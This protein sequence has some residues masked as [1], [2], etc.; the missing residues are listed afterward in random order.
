MEGLFCYCDVLLAFYRIEFAGNLQ[1]LAFIGY[2]EGTYPSKKFGVNGIGT[3]FPT[4][5]VEVPT[6]FPS[7]MEGSH[8]FAQFTSAALPVAEKSG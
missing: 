3:I 6:T 8:T 4:F 7:A 5:V 2:L 1:N